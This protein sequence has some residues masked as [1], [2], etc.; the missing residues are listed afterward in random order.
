MRTFKA[1]IELLGEEIEV[2]SYT[3]EFS[4]KT[5]NKGRPCT[6]TLGGRF[7]F[8]TEATSSTFLAELMLNLNHK[9]VLGRIR[10]FHPEDNKTMGELTFRDAFV[11]F[12]KES[13]YINKSTPIRI[14]CTLTARV[15]AIGHA[16]Q[17]SGW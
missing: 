13:C 17:D 4:R 9:P 2:I 8:V 1:T 15:V 7:T 5:D 16:Y 14:T 10:F 11:V 3:I 12:Y 6:P